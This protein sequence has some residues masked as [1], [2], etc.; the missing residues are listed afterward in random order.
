M[1][2][3][4]FLI[5]LF[6][7]MSQS[8]FFNSFVM[9]GDDEEWQVQK[10]NK[11]KHKRESQQQTSLSIPA[12]AHVYVCIYTDNHVLV[13][14][15]RTSQYWFKGGR[16]DRSQKNFCEI[17][18]GGNRDK[19]CIYPDG[20]PSNDLCDEPVFPGG[21]AEG[22]DRTLWRAAIR[23]FREETSFLLDDFI[24]EHKDTVTKEEKRI[25]LTSTYAL[26]VN[27]EKC[28]REIKLSLLNN[29]TRSLNSVDTFRQWIKEYKSSIKSSYLSPPPI[30]DTDE[31]ES[32]TL[33]P[34]QTL[35]TTLDPEYRCRE[36][37]I[38]NNIP[39]AAEDNPLLVLDA[40]VIYTKEKTLDV[41]GDMQTGL[42]EENQKMSPE[43]LEAY[44]QQTL[45]AGTNDSS[46][47]T[48]NVRE[49]ILKEEVPGD[50]ATES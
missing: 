44:H 30:I 2:K 38:I 12:D 26:Y 9:S 1:L 31:L 21:A 36:I 43:E 22:A 42:P 41:T 8:V 50:S 29:I 32:V 11:K 14:Q 34:I 16:L 40:P 47:S 7:F 37:T 35:K 48:S 25:G 17:Y 24:N 3:K 45:T 23:E 10:G 39:K 49:M 33:I 4:V 6:M 27:I 46:Q 19:Y 13:A 18:L 15:K 28:S 5:L 20:R